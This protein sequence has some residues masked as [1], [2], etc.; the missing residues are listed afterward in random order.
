MKRFAVSVV[1]GVGA[2]LAVASGAWA[3][4]PVFM[5]GFA[6]HGG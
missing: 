5:A 6:T 2:M 4:S 3:F 1:L